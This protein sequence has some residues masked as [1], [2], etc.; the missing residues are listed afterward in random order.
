[1]TLKELMHLAQ[2][3]LKAATAFPVKRGHV[4]ELLAAAA[5]FKTW[6]A[7]DSA[8]FLADKGTDGEDL[9]AHALIVGRAI[10]LEIPATDALRVAQ[11]LCGLVEELKLSFVEREKLASVLHRTPP[12]AREY[13][14]DEDEWSEDDWEGDWKE[15]R[16]TDE[17][18]R[19][20]GSDPATKVQV[21]RLLTTSPLL[22]NCLERAVKLR[23]NDAVAH[24][25]L[26]TFYRCD[27]PSPYLYEESLKGR[28]LST[29]EQGWADNYLRA[30][31]VYEKYFRHLRTA[32]SLGDRMAALEYAEVVTGRTAYE[33][34]DQMTGHVDAARMAAIAPDE[35]H[36]MKWFRVAAD[37]GSIDALSVLARRGDVDAL[38][39]LAALGDLD[40]IRTLAIDAVDQNQSTDAW[41]WQHLALLHGE[42][43]TVSTMRAYHDGGQRDGQFYN[44]DFGGALY[45][46]GDEGLDLP[47]I[48]KVELAEA[49]KRARDI[50]DS[51][52]ARR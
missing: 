40:A 6:A 26:A 32:T 31:P 9:K 23:P 49:K 41:Q 30:A 10:Q 22:L 34:V 25:A 38:K 36:R 48:S 47:Q 29:I 43:L 35:T 20:S 1:M 11:A 17:P 42:D 14:D 19:G 8:A 3:R 15:H 7:F 21:Q 45:A 27:R 50:F 18:K 51:A 28:K 46:E 4:L 37:E 5:R 2:L 33:A 13:L 52:E 24:F 16:E 12:H 39:Q 44:S